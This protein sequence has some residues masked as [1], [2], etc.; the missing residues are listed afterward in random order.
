[1]PQIFAL[2]GLGDTVFLSEVRLMFDVPDPVAFAVVD[3]P[4]WIK[5]RK[6]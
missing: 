4:G 2:A 1:M 5:P 3:A 6:P